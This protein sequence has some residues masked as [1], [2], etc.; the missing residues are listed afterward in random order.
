MIIWKP[1]TKYRY[2]EQRNEVKYHTDLALEEGDRLED[3]KELMEVF[4][5]KPSKDIG[6]ILRYLLEQ[7]IE[8]PAVNNRKALL[9][10]ALDFI[11]GKEN[12]TNDRI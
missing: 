3:C 10:C 6:V 2:S 5:M 11:E 7:V 12:K 8:E 4:S 1:L 9:H